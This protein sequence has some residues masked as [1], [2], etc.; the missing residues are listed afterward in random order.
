ML[1]LSILQPPPSAFE[2][3]TRFS[4]ESL[5]YHKPKLLVPFRYYIILLVARICDSLGLDWNQAHT[6]MLNKISGLLAVKYNNDP[7]MPR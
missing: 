6:H 7:I 4:D 1:F 2:N 5:K 3:P